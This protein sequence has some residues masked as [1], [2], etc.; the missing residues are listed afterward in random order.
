[1]NNNQESFGVR[2]LYHTPFYPACRKIRVM[3][4]E[5]GVSAELVEEP[6]WEQRPQ[7]LAMNPAGELPIL[8]DGDGRCVCGSYAI[9]EYLDEGYHVGDF[10]GTTLD[11]RAEVRRLVAWADTKMLKEVTQPLIYEKYFRHLRKQGNP[12][13]GKIRQAK[14][15]LVYHMGYFE[16]LLKQRS[17]MASDRYTLA[18]IAL[19]SH[20]SLCDYMGDVAWKDNSYLKRWYALMKSR[21]AF[22]AILTDRV[23]GIKPPEHYENPDF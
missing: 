10:I 6:A 8:I 11:E 18:D 12:D 7:F 1:M 17:W 16:Q 5:M 20:L 15:H 22:R 14:A 2:R 13:S 23:R 19:A 3:M 9:A 21:P 4:A